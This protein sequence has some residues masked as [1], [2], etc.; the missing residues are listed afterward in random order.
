MSTIINLKG[1]SALNV[2]GAT[3]ASVANGVASFT[4]GGVGGVNEQTSNYLAVSNDNGKIVAMKGTSLTLT[5]PA[6]PPSTTWAIFI[7]NIST[8]STLTVSR[9]G[10]LI[11][12]QAA[13]LTLPSMSGVYLSTDGTNYFTSRGLLPAGFLS[14]TAVFVTSSIPYLGV[15]TGTVTIAKGYNLRSV[16]VSQTARLRLFATA[17][18]RTADGNRSN[19][20]PPTP[21]TQH[22]VHADLYLDTAD[23]LSWL[24]SPPAPGY[25]GDGPQTSTIYYSVTNLSQATGPIT[26]TLNFTPVEA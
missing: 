22:G 7:A 21:G 25:N 24:L 19:M 8:T 14:G 9:N 10:L 16:V 20:T 23:K 15:A 5:L 2:T 4:V 12:D 17:A 3:T 18:A 11:D 13:N 26:V 1:I 6:V